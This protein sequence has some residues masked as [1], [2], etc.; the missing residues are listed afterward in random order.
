[1]TIKSVTRS[2]RRN[3]GSTRKK[4][5]KDQP[6]STTTTPSPQHHPPGNTPSSNSSIVT[7]HDGNQDTLLNGIGPYRFHGP[8]GSGKFSR[9][10]LARHRD[11]GKQVAIKI[12]DKQAHEYRVMSRLV[13]E[14]YLMEM[15]DHENIVKL[16]ETIETCDSLFLVMEY[17]PGVNLDEYLHRQGGKLKEDEARRYFRQMVSAVY[18]CHNRWVVHRDLKTPNVLITPDGVVKLADFGLGNRFGLQRLKTIC[19]SMLYYSPEI[20][21][22]QK[23]FGPEVDCWCL[24]I[25]LFR[26]TAGYEPFSHAHTVGELKRDVCNCNYKMPDSISPELQTTIRKCLQTDR[27]KR[28]TVRQALKDDPWLTKNGE[29]SCPFSDV[30]KTAYDEIVGDDLGESSSNERQ[31]RERRARRQFMKDLE[32]DSNMHSSVKHTIVYHPVNPSTYFTTGM[33]PTN[34]HHHHQ[35]HNPPSHRIHQHHYHYQHENIEILRS[36]LLQS[37]RTRVKRLGM[38]SAERWGGTA[39]ALRLK[40]SEVEKANGNSNNGSGFK[41]YDMMQRLTRCQ[42]YCFHVNYKSSSQP[43]PPPSL[44]SS[45]N[46]STSTSSSPSTT[47][48]HPSMGDHGTHSEHQHNSSLQKDFMALLKLTCQLMGVTYSQ[49]SPTRLLCVLTL[50]EPSKDDKKPDGTSSNRPPPP[51]KMR[52]RTSRSSTRSST[53]ASSTDEIIIGTEPFRHRRMSLP[54]ISHLTSSMTTSFFGRAKARQS[55]DDK[56]DK[57]HGQQQQQQ[58]TQHKKRDS[59]AVFSIDIEQRP[60][61]HATTIVALRFSRQQGS[62]TVFKMAGGWITGVLSL[63]PQE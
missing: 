60:G 47:L 9:V 5:P 22:G 7:P 50:R 46:M 43:H 25:A 29:L 57:Q 19:G 35:Q 38:R 31:E 12:I 62:N 39:L 44:S 26:M 2:L 48:S 52:R 14:I 41:F 15:L 13:R 8:L 33:A 6:S 53:A 23:Y 21:T 58:P 32:R 10:V 61:A 27:R 49:E 34:C 24:G 63:P 11:T 37:I 17:I 18:F 54:L 4:T 45:S 1:M 16:Y 51:T 3:F 30:P 42:V 55:T 40:P 56:A 28:M 36:E 20:I 59:L